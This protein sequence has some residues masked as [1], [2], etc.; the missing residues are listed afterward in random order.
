MKIT[1][2][3]FWDGGPTNIL[4]EG[5]SAT[6]RILLTPA[7]AGIL[8]TRALCEKKGSQLKMIDNIENMRLWEQKI[9]K[10]NALFF[11]LDGTL[12]D[13]DYA[14]FLSYKKAIEQIKSS[15]FNVTIKPKKR[16]TRKNIRTFV[17][18]LSEEEYKKIIKIKES[19]YHLYLGDTK[20]NEAVADMLNKY[21]DKQIFLVTNSHKERADFLLNHFNL[22]NKFTRKYY[23]EN[24]TNENKFQHVLS[25]LRIDSSLVFVFENNE[26]EINAAVIAG[27][28]LENILKVV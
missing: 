15:Q 21:S 12:I 16:I 23:K 13:T 10:A 7:F 28:P 6:L 19:L 27:I 11:D 4:L 9:R 2:F 14:N 5:H 17:P 18:D 20:L 24:M 3:I 1:V 22:I 26:S 25:T 8:T